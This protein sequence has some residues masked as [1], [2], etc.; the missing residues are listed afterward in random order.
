MGRSRFMWSRSYFFLNCSLA[1]FICMC[2]AND[3]LSPH[4]TTPNPT[5]HHTTQPFIRWPFRSKCPPLSRY[6]TPSCCFVL[7]QPQPDSFLLSFLVQS[8]LLFSMCCVFVVLRTPIKT[9]T[10]PPPPIHIHL[11]LSPGAQQPAPAHQ[12]RRAGVGG[13][14][15]VR[16][17]E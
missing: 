6:S 15:S 14:S 16:G 9:H 11:H 10:S 5:P 17:Q 12:G 13:R 2:F 8:L 4:L 1:C 7:N 3:H